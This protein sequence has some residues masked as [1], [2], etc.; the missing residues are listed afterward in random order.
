MIVKQIKRDYE[1]LNGVKTLGS[2]KNHFITQNHLGFA[3]LFLRLLLF[4]LYFFRLLKLCLATAKSRIANRKAKKKQIKRQ[5]CKQCTCMQQSSV[6][7]V[8]NVHE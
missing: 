1:C 3:I 7:H 5:T 2:V 8:A 4:L 6:Q